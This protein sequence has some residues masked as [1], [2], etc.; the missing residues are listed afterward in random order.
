M[1]RSYRFDVYSKDDYRNYDLSREKRSRVDWRQQY[2]LHAFGRYGGVAVAAVVGLVFHF[3]VIANNRSGYY[4]GPTSTEHYDREHGVGGAQAIANQQVK[5]I[6]ASEALV[7]I[8]PN[9][10]SYLHGL[11]KKEA[12]VLTGRKFLSVGS[13]TDSEIDENNEATS[14]ESKN[15]LSSLTRSQNDKLPSKSQ[16]V[17]LPFVVQDGYN[18]T[19]V[20]QMLLRVIVTQ[21]IRSMVVV[22]CGKHI[23]WMGRF[24]EGTR[25]QLPKPFVFYCVDSSKRAVRE[26]EDIVGEVEGVNT[27]FIDRQFWSVPLPRADLVFSW[28]GLDGLSLLHAHKM[29]ATIIK[30]G[31]HKLALLGSTPSTKHNSDRTPLNLRRAPFSYSRPLKMYKELYS[32]ESLKGRDK[33]LYLYEVRKMEHKHVKDH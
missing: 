31:H 29:L 6:N 5:P 32:K 23:S 14:S 4:S 26:A 11:A 15:D 1:P 13:E 10:A 19:R 25:D 7:R 27:N 18:I 12:D 17:R 24:L 33:Q 21:N 22:P 30:Q 20:S 28:D 16:T 9:F 3:L 8:D 2:N